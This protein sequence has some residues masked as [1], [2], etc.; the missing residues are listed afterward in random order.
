M[1]YMGSNTE[2]ISTF[3]LEIYAFRPTIKTKIKTYKQ[4]IGVSLILA[5]T[6]NC[7]SLW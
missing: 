6:Y 2:N 1:E 3:R 5:R 4:K 7:R